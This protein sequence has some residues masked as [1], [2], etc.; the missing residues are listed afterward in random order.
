MFW[1]APT[2]AHMQPVPQGDAQEHDHEGLINLGYNF[3]GRPDLFADKLSIMEPLLSAVRL[4]NIAADPAQVLN[5]PEDRFEDFDDPD[6]TSEMESDNVQNVPDFFAPQD[7]WIFRPDPRNLGIRNSLHYQADRSTTHQD[8]LLAITTRWP[9][10][11]PGA[12]WTLIQVELGPLDLLHPQIRIG[13]LAYVLR[14]PQDLDED[15]RGPQRIVLMNMRT[16]NLWTGDATGSHFN[17]VVLDSHLSMEEFR[18]EMDFFGRCDNSP[19]PIEINGIVQTPWGPRTQIFLADGDFFQIFSVLHAEFIP[20]ATA[21]HRG[22]GLPPLSQLPIAFASDAVDR[23]TSDT[24][25]AQDIA[26]VVQ[27]FQ[28]V[29]TLWAR[30]IFQR[31]NMN[32][33]D[34]PDLLVFLPEENYVTFTSLSAM[35]PFDALALYFDIREHVLRGADEEWELI[36]VTQIPTPRLRVD[37]RFVG[38]RKASTFD[39]WIPTVLTL[40]E[41][42]FATSFPGTGRYS[43]AS[44]RSRYMPPQMTKQEIYH[45]LHLAE[46]CAHQ[47]CYLLVDGRACLQQ[48]VLLQ[49]GSFLQVYIGND[50]DEVREPTIRCY[51]DEPPLKRS[52]ATSSTLAFAPTQLLTPCASSTLQSLTLTWPYPQVSL[53]PWIWT[54]WECSDVLLDLVRRIGEAAHP[55]PFWLGTTNP[56]GL[57]RKEDAYFELPTGLWGISE[58]HLTSL[59][60]RHASSA[61]YRLGQEHHRSLQLLHGAPVAP[62]SATMMAGT[63]SGVSL[64][65]DAILRPIELHWPNAEYSQGRIQMAQTW[66]GPWSMT[67]A[68]IYAWSKGPTWPRALQLTN[69]MLDYLT[70][71]LVLS[72]DGPR[73]IMGDFNHPEDQLPCIAIWKQ[74]GWVEVQAW[75]EQFHGRLPTPTSKHTNFLDR[76]YV[77]PELLPYLREVQ[78]WDLFTDHI[79]LGA[80]LDP[81]VQPHVQT[82]WPLPGHVPFH[83]VDR[84]AWARSCNEQTLSFSGTADEQFQRFG[85]TYE[86]S[87]DTFVKTPHQT[88]PNQMRGRGQ[89]I[90]PVSRPG[91]CPLLRPSRPGEVALA[92]SFV[93]RG[94]QKWFLQLRRLQSMKHALRAAKSTEQAQIYRAQ[95]WRAIRKSSGFDPSFPVWWTQRPI[96]LQG[97]PSQVP[98]RVPT[99]SELEIIYLDFERNFKRFEAWHGKQR[100]ELLQ[101]SLQAHQAKIFS[102]IKPSGK[103]PLRHL[104][105]AQPL[106]VLAVSDDLTQLHLAEAVEASPMLSLDIDGFHSQDFLV[107]GPVITLP[108]ALSDIPSEVT[109]T[110][111]WATA[112]QIHDRLKD[113]WRPRW[114]QDNLPSEADW[115]RVLNFCQSR[116]PHI[117]AQHQPIT[118]DQWAAINSRYTPKSARGPDGYSHLDLKYMPQMLQQA[119]VQQVNRWEQDGVFPEALL[120]GFVHP[121]PKRLDSCKVED[122][123]PVIIFSTLYR[124]WSSLR[125]R[126]E[127]ARLQHRVGRHQF[128]FIPEREPGQ[129]WLM[130]QAHIEWATQQGLTRLGFVTDVQKAFEH[131][132]RWPLF[133]LA[134]QMGVSPHVIRLWNYFLTHMHR[135][136]LLGSQIGDPMWSNNGLPEGCAMSCLGMALA[137]LAFHEYMAHFSNQTIALSFVDNLELLASSLLDLQRGITCLQSWLD[138]WHLLLDGDKSY[139]WSNDAPTRTNS[140]ILGWE[141]KTHAKDL[142]APMVYGKQRSVQDQLLRLHSLDQLW[143]LLRILDAP[144]W[145]KMQLLRQAFWPRAFYGSAICCLGNQHIKTLRTKAVRAFKCARG[146]ANPLIRLGLLN[147]PETDPG[148][149]QLVQVVFTFRRIAQKQP[150]MRDLWTSYMMAFDGT[151]HNGPFSKLLEVLHAIGWSVHPPHVHDH[152]GIGL[153]LTQCE[154]AALKRHLID[155]WKQYAASQFASRRD[156]QGLHGIDGFVLDEVQKAFP[157]HQVATVQVLQDG[158]FLEPSRQQKYDAFQDG[159]C[160]LCRQLDTLAHRAHT[161]PGRQALYDQYPDIQQQWDHLNTSLKLRLLPSR[162]PWYASFMKALSIYPGDVYY[163]SK[164]AATGDLHLFTDGSCW[165][166]NKPWCSLGA[167]AVLDATTDRV[168]VRGTLPGLHQTSY[169]AELFAVYHAIHLACD[170]SSPTYLWVDNANI[171]STLQ[172]ALTS[173]VALDDLDDASVWEMILL[174]LREHQPRL[175][176][177]HVASH[178]NSP[179][180]WA[181]VDDWTGYWNDRVDHEAA[182]AHRLR[183]T[184]LHDLRTRMIDA[185]LYAKNL[186]LRLYHFHLGLFQTLPD[187][188]QADEMV[189]EPVTDTFAADPDELRLQI[190]TT[191]QVELPENPLCHPGVQRLCNNFPAQFVSELLLWLRGESLKAD[192]V[193]LQLT[194]LEMAT[195]TAA[196]MCCTG[197]PLPDP[198]RSHHWRDAAELPHMEAGPTMALVLKLHK[199]FFRAASDIFDFDLDPHCKVSLAHRGVA[200]PQTG[201]MLMISRSTIKKIGERLCAFTARRLIRTSNDLARPLN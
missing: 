134:S 127:L 161:C 142:G 16:W 97:T 87:F 182:L 30:D 180:Q 22:V 37:Q 6:D 117:E 95:L 186:L 81:P 26:D 29:L 49:E 181:D 90:K 126:Q 170:R 1:F 201:I 159:I 171:A 109:V 187:E 188:R 103:A 132:P 197:I 155:G 45:L 150:F 131:L 148:C 51:E 69:Q 183:P 31:A 185:H 67:G 70:Q 108:R 124:S 105:D 189:E 44:Y 165:E 15:N 7:L 160:P 19:C 80:C 156:V 192:V 43:A 25:P 82:T 190:G 100:R 39:P 121:L 54:L 149:F 101:A 172:I 34:V 144:T 119:L 120:P 136:F 93:G 138:Q 17:A 167:F 146:G 169:K 178:R 104:I 76:I 9:D 78:T 47:D 107:D 28:M 114:W 184:A 123:R 50:L 141:V 175:F 129:L 65:S 57:R 73:F 173:P 99:L 84:D 139:V 128:G 137:N 2:M 46:I 112:E 174:L 85:Q 163:A 111:H 191:W 154:P 96:R 5:P 106:E 158:T 58:T 35:E 71:E 75:A 98:L 125:A 92:H 64:L 198:H 200:V 12:P 94:V 166:P 195:A 115:T 33:I 74:Q 53:I 179:V 66:I 23:L 55:G 48:Q 59:G 130:L 145:K 27:A 153:D 79:V 8:L 14:S 36:P 72:R 110:R 164:P 122:Y 42:H 196:G 177:Q 41:L 162:N 152:D 61:I 4:A 116:L 18:T 60:Q 89:V 147:P 38:I 151:L 21:D 77:S 157:A 193:T 199:H 40:A 176:V 88:L 168:L 143:P 135:R 140:L 102:L 63:W 194:Y 13:A 32:F 68:N 52:R 24:R 113:F 20:R 118:V 11:Q 56:S 3:V 62:R 91:Q 10:L 86:D 83:L 133:C